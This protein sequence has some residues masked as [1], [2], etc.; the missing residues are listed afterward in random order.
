ML[1]AERFYSACGIFHPEKAATPLR[2]G[3]NSGRMSGGIVPLRE[4]CQSL[5]GLWVNFKS[6]RR[7]KASLGSFLRQRAKD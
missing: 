4:Q 1:H 2:P 3:R 7:S 6:S 5:N